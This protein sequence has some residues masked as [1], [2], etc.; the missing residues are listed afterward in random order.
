MTRH[1]GV[2]EPAGPDAAGQLDSG[3]LAMLNQA[4]GIYR[5]SQRAT[6][7]LRR[8][9][10]RLGEPLRVAVTGPRGAGKTTV[11]QAMDGEP[12]L[13][14]IDAPATN[15]Q[16]PA[17]LVPAEADAVLYVVR[18]RGEADIPLLRAAMANP[19]AAAAP[20]TTI[21]VLTRAD[22]TGDGLVDALST[23]KQ[24]AR[25]QRRDLELR[26]LCQNVVAL[27]GLIAMA[28]RT[29]GDAEFAA[30]AAL[31]RAPRAEL[32][33]CLLSADRFT[34]PDCPAG[35]PAT[36]R[37]D[38]LDRFGL[39][40]IRLS[41][42]L[43]RTGWDSQVTL[44]AELVSRSGLSELRDLVRQHFVDRRATLK[45]RSA[46]LALD[47]VLRMEPRPEGRGLAAELERVLASA[48]ELRE[49]RLLAAL[50][51]G[52]TALPGDGA[53]RAVRLIGG[54]GTSLPARLGVD[55]RA[56]DTELRIAAMDALD[57]WQRQAGDPELAASQRRAAQ[58][59]VRT[60]EGI[61]TA[62]Q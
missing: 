38:L 35:L 30:L 20:V 58:V 47:V 25:R 41:T 43:I 22:E 55:P 12:G 7:W 62:L 52:R 28:G 44:S 50:Q 8:N 34:G 37:H 29:M 46:L 17:P 4:L 33:R 10:D 53:D 32:D 48:H 23:A 3:A 42:T 36:T 59:V 6:R 26:G 14:L 45:A 56:T 51:T 54:T 31:A 9:V 49:L 21:V 27:S 60:C 57:H 11:V 13:A 16:A 39:L 61:L 19:V 18:N 40:G 1:V 2:Q 5:G 15:P 24:L